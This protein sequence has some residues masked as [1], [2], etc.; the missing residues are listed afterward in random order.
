[1]RARERPLVSH[2]NL[3]GHRR[4]TGLVHHQFSCP[5]PKRGLGQLIPQNLL[6]ALGQEVSPQFPR[7]RRR[8]D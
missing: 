4:R 2:L 1:M 8:P 5:L 3:P 6:Q 7:N